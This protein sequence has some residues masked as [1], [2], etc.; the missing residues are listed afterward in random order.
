MNKYIQVP[1]NTHTHTQHVWLDWAHQEVQLVLYVLKQT[2]HHSGQVYNVGGVVL[3]KQ[4]PRLSDVTVKVTQCVQNNVALIII[5]PK[6]PVF[7]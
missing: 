3:L 6:V 2:T 4:H 7:G 1:V 5:I